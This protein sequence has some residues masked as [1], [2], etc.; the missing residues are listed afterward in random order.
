LIGAHISPYILYG[1]Q[2]MEFFLFA[3]DFVCL[4]AF[5][6]KE[7]LIFLR[8]ICRPERRG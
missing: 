3:A 5:V 4:V 6:V 8:D 1:V 7:T 2:G